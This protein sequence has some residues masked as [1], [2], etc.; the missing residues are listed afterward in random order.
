MTDFTGG[1]WRSLIDGQEV[2]P[3]PNN[4]IL[5]PVS[6]DLD[7]FSG[8]TGEYAIDSNA[9]VFDGSE[10]LKF[11]NNQ[12]TSEIVSTTGLSNYP[13]V[14]KIHTFFFDPQVDTGDNQSPQIGVRFGY[15]GNDGYSLVFINGEMR[16]RRYDGGSVT[17]IK[18]PSYTLLDDWQSVEVLHESDGT[19]SVTVRDASSLSRSNYRNGSVRLSDSVTDTTYITNGSYDQTGVGLNSGRNYTEVLD[20]WYTE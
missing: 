11:S 14:D 7:N 12:I 18:S 16:F 3:I 10:S 15:D 2:I 20:A 17:D 1:A 9:P 6:G 19:W 8:P 5:K 13:D 4:P